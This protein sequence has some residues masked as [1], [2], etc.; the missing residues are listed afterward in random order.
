[1]DS[2]NS[3]GPLDEEIDS[4]VAFDSEDEQ[5]YG[6]FFANRKSADSD[7]QL[8]S[9]NDEMDA[10]ENGSAAEEGAISL[11]DI[12]KQNER[13]ENERTPNERTGAATTEDGAGDS[14]EEGEEDGE[15]S[16]SEDDLEDDGKF[17]ALLQSIHAMDG[18]K[19]RKVRQQTENVAESEFAVQGKDSVASD[20]LSLSDLLAPSQKGFS[21]R[22]QKLLN[23]KKDK[24]AQMLAT[25]LPE[26][27]KERIERKVGY[28]ATKKDVSKWQGLVKQNR[29][30]EQLR[31]AMNKKSNHVVSLASMN[32][33]FTASNDFEKDFENLLKG[34][35]M[36][37][38]SEASIRETEELAFNEMGPEEAKLRKKQIQKMRDVMFHQEIKFKRVKK[39]KSKEYRRQLRKLRKKHQLSVE[40]IQDLDPDLAF[41]EQ[42]K[43]EFRRA[44]ERMTLRHKNV[45]KWARRLNQRENLG[46]KAKAA[47]E[48][49]LKL[50]QDLRQ[51]M[52]SMESSDESGPDMD[53]E[54]EDSDIDES[55]ARS[56]HAAELQSAESAEAPAPT[57]VF[58]LKFMRRAEEKKKKD[59]EKMLTEMDE[60]QVEGLRRVAGEKD[61]DPAASGNASA[62]S[63]DVSRVAAGRKTFGARGAESKSA[64]GGAG[65]ADATSA[66]E[67]LADSLQS[68]KV[69]LSIGHKTRV[70]GFLTVPASESREPKEKEEGLFDVIEFSDDETHTAPDCGPLNTTDLEI[71]SD[72]PKSS[73]TENPK[74]LPKSSR[75]STKSS[76]KTTKTAEKEGLQAEDA[77]DLDVAASWNTVPGSSCKADK[78]TASLSSPKPRSVTQ[79]SS[80]VANHLSTSQSS[81]PV[82]SSRPGSATGESGTSAAEE[83]RQ[84]KVANQ[85]NP[86]LTAAPDS[87]ISSDLTV[88]TKK[89]P[90]IPT[91][92]DMSDQMLVAE[93]GEGFNLLGSSAE[94]RKLVAR[95]FADAGVEEGEFE[96]E[97]ATL[98]DEEMPKEKKNFL[99][100]W[101]SW[102]GMGVKQRKSRKR[103]AEQKPTG[104]FKSKRKDAKLKHVIINEKKDKKSAGYRLA[105]HPW[106]YTNSAQ[107]ER[108]LQQPVGKEWNTAATFR[109]QI[110]S[111][112]VTRQG[113]II[114]PIKFSETIKEKKKRS[115]EANNAQLH[116]TSAK[117]KKRRRKTKKK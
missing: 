83:R 73:E 93:D 85:E 96:K 20:K 45:G 62:L 105:S 106:P 42:Y 101:G 109:D 114:E 2:F 48:E 102:T 46:E 70:G 35:G 84:E 89:K 67:V 51:K 111:E 92:L 59:F 115:R 6:D 29:E 52:N 90:K 95:A 56:K 55:S 43:R 72:E 17:G 27:Q 66:S 44:E 94:Q 77:L 88:K 80:P 16:H 63:A 22:Q 110:K 53:F 98:L 71:V 97:K 100:G 28:E 91:E 37:K 24:V 32:A 82:R 57:G 1:M 13:T 64:T 104:D 87:E 14:G 61:T 75:K 30:L 34:M 23:L 25:P 112:V 76:P 107:Y 117:R 41:E 49:Q 5:K 108:S 33:K 12:F 9:D 8:S 4:D 78:T 103:K 26:V 113:T 7:D 38:G 81:S 74:K 36:A 18:Q 58:A 54:D 19:K 99:A 47:L 86:W 21:K 60:E 10:G 79:S 50:G 68:V 15:L 69:G 11:S 116:G 40:E 65:R 39:I 31:F 3:N